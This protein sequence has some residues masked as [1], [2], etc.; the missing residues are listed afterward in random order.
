MSTTTSSDDGLSTETVEQLKTLADVIDV[1]PD[2]VVKNAL[3]S[4]EVIAGTANKDTFKTEKGWLCNRANHIGFYY[5]YE[6]VNGQA[7][8]AEDRFNG[9]P[10]TAKKCIV[11]GLSEDCV[12]FEAENG[13]HTVIMQRYIDVVEDVFGIDVI[14]NPSKATMNVTLEGWPIRVTHDQT[15]NEIV[16][17]PVVNYN[18]A[19]TCDTQ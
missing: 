13:T 15:G 17:A 11:E 3:S 16:I 5:D 9:V 12:M 8:I 10:E 6:A 18:D 2:F 4:A 19:V 7:T 1:A 14:E